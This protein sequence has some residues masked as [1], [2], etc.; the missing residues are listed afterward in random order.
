MKRHKETKRDRT[1]TPTSETTLGD[2]KFRKRDSI[3]KDKPRSKTKEKHSEYGKYESETDSEDDRHQPKA[4]WE[5]RHHS[6]QTP[7]YRAQQKAKSKGKWR[8]QSPQRER[9]P[10][11][12]RSPHRQRSPQRQRSP[13]RQ[14]S[15]QRQCSPKRQH[16][17]KRQRSPQRQRSPKR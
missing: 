16:S 12:Q 4:Y 5:G 13:K 7:R 1:T 6:F 17:P 14:Y 15:H 10:Q 11:R 3:F 2:I 8:Q 9:S